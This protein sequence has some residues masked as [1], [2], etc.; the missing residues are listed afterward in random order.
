VSLSEVKHQPFAQR[1]IQQ[2]LDRA[3]M[4]HGY[5]FHGPN[6]V[7]KELLARG[8]AQLLLCPR[9]VERTFTGEQA[10]QIVA[11]RLREGCGACADCRLVAAETH[12][13]FHLIYRQLNRDHPD[14]DVRKRKGLGLGVEV[15]RHFVVDRVA[16]TPHHGRAKV[17]VIREAD[18]MNVQAQNALLKT[19]EEPPGT[20]FLVLLASA[21]DSLLPTTQSRCQ[22]V[23]FDALP[24]AFVK[25]RLAELRPALN[26][27]QLGWYTATA[28]GSIGQ[29]LEDADNDTFAR[30]DWIVERLA[31]A[32]EAE[33]A[34]LAE[35]WS[36]TADSL[37][38]RYRKLDADITDTDATRR[39]LRVALRLT[40]NW[41]VDLLRGTA[42]GPRGGTER[43]AAAI[44]RIAQ[45]EQQLE[46]NVNTHLCLETLANDLVNLTAGRELVRA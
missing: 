5:I 41:Y 15:V 30:N 10:T 19:L 20:T 22:I 23:R 2:A 28:E 39:G 1:M 11:A 16:L 24:A 3:R 42:G 6:G 29:A 40:A 7:G 9:P 37:G 45:A 13:D 25:S 38:E 21:L 46:L 43:L 27:E 32:A 8:L 35:A 18:D 14:P 12:P 31:A 26:E 36:Q 34:Q 17:F 44:E 4:P 33:P